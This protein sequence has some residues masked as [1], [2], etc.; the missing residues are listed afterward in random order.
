M[1]EKKADP[2]IGPKFLSLV[3]SINDYRYFKDFTDRT[4]S[5]WQFCWQFVPEMSCRQFR[6]IRWCGEGDLNPHALRR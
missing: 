5:K 6:H 2:G 3:R 1:H 4:K